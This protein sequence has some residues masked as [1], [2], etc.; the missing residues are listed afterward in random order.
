MMLPFTMKIGPVAVEIAGT[1][2][3]S[4][5]ISTVDLEYIRKCW[6]E[7]KPLVDKVLVEELE[8][9]NS[10]STRKAKTRLAIGILNALGRHAVERERLKNEL[11]KTG[12]FSK[13]EAAEFLKD[14]V[15]QRIIYEGENGFYATK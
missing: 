2:N 13:E 8:I 6:I 11:I 5:Y 3:E 14:A 10:N 15:S 1:G 12:E 9:A 7:L 4:K